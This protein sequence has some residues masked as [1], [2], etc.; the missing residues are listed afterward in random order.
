[1]G[2][3]WGHFLTCRPHFCLFFLILFL[4]FLASLSGRRRRQEFI[5]VTML[6]SGAP[7]P[8]RKGPFEKPVA[9][10]QKH[11]WL[12]V[13]AAHWMQKGERVG[14]QGA[15]EGPGEPRAARASEAPPKDLAEITERL[16]ETSQSLLR[17]FPET[18]QEPLESPLRSSPQRRHCP[19]R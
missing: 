16:P 9:R 18:S 7:T 12:R 5:C 13:R 6:C 2:S 10:F 3:G 11:M 14:E 15:R 1:M 19:S 4:C 8:S 17:V